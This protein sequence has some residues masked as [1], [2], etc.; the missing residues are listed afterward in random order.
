M[1][2]IT[3]H[4]PKHTAQG[5]IELFVRFEQFPDEDLPFHAHSKDEE[6]HGRELYARA[7]AGEFGAVLPYAAP[8]LPLS[9]LA[10]QKLEQ[11]QAEKA[12][13]MNGG[14]MHGGVLYDSD[15][16]ARTAYLE[17]AVKL[18]QTPG[19]ATAWKASG[20]SWVEMNAALFASLQP[21]YETHVSGCFA[22]Q[23]GKQAEVAAALATE[24][25]EALEA[26]STV[27]E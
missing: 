13:V 15:L 20:E 1:N 16:A 17:L 6:A 24:D 21:A 12:R 10:E 7:L 25:R 23:A 11:L 8:V 14:F 27:W 5:G 2:I 22:W 26:I 19:Y 9:E 4:T 18:G 3:A